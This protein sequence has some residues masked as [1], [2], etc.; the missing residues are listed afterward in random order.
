MG[1]RARDSVVDRYSMGQLS[2]RIGQI[3]GEAVKRTQ[4]SPI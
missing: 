2:R 4:S 1:L 3:Y